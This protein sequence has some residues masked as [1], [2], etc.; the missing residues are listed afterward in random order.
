[1]PNIEKEQAGV[2]VTHKGDDVQPY[3]V[4]KHHKTWY[5]AEWIGVTLATNN[6][7]ILIQLFLQFQDV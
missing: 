7:E 1:M 3:S 2:Q 4:H 5:T 6:H